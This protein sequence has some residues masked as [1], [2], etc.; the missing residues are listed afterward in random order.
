MKQNKIDS[1]L[2]AIFGNKIKGRWKKLMIC[3]IVIWL[4]IWITIFIIFNVGYNSENGFYIKPT[5]AKI[6]VDIKRGQ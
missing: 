6:N 1:F 3:I 5:E 2:D 4:L